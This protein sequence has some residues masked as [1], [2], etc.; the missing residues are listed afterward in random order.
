VSKGAKVDVKDRLGR[1]PWSMAAALYPSF[2]SASANSLVGLRPH[3]ATADLLLKLG[4]T[5]MTEKDFP[6]I[7]NRAYAND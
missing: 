5:R 6:R 1:T 3:P 7:K 4:A 2:D